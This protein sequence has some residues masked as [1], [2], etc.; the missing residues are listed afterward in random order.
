MNGLCAKFFT[1]LFQ[2]LIGRLKTKVAEQM[3]R[4]LR[5][6]FQSLIGRLKTTLEALECLQFAVFQS[7]IGRLKTHSF[8]RLLFTG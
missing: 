5:Q 1:Q 2:S 8:P 4:I 6:Q 3:P 7:L